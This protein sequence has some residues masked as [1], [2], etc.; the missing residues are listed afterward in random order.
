[1]A[2]L[3]YMGINEQDTSR[4]VGIELK[5]RRLAACVCSPQKTQK[6]PFSGSRYFQAKNKKAYTRGY[7]VAVA[8]YLRAHNVDV[9]H[10]AKVNC[11][12]QFD[13]ACPTD[14][15]SASDWMKGWLDGRDF[16]LES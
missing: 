4:R 10:L 2:Y 6:T 9:L 15:L 11:N 5:N 16:Q 7:M 12:E 14:A 3:L 1:M 8:N 13:L